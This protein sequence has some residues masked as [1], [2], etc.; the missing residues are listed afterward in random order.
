MSLT[1]RTRAWDL[2]AATSC[3]RIA[4]IAPD[5]ETVEVWDLRNKRRVSKF[6]AIHDVGG[7]R[8]AISPD[9]S[10]VA[11]AAYSAGRISCYDVMSGNKRWSIRARSCQSVVYSADGT[12]LF[13]GFDSRS[14]MQLE[15]E[16]GKCI[17]EIPGATSIFVSPFTRHIAEER[18]RLTLYKPGDE[19]IGEI[20]EQPRIAAVAFSPKIVAL[21][22]Y[23]LSEDVKPSVECVS[24]RSGKQIWRSQLADGGAFLGLVWNKDREVFFGF[25]C[26][27]PTPSWGR[28]LQFS[29]RD[30]ACSQTVDVEFDIHPVFD[31][32]G[33]RLILS[34]GDVYSTLTGRRLARL[35]LWS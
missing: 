16:S 28:L 33:E 27:G 10:T 13:A 14:M 21:S 12:Y 5:G 23:C 15:V 34:T 24:L 18:R 3:S 19:L 1:K 8:L 32:H 30:G 2:V 26:V 22:H 35:A 11:T 25:H 6:S 29:E 17:R 20:T 31:Q 9:G 7:R 4:A